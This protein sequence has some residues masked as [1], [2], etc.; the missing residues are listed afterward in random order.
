MCLDAHPGLQGLPARMA[1]PAALPPCSHRLP[2]PRNSYHV[3][4][5]RPTPGTALLTASPASGRPSPLAL[6]TR[7]LASHCP[8]H[9]PR[10]LSSPGDLGQLP[11]HSSA[12]ITFLKPPPNP[13]PPDNLP[14]L[15]SLGVLLIL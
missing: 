5:A 4:A 14:R 10:L 7:P 13:Q 11:D 12:R 6:P 15:L 3:P 1:P 8:C 9:A 2:H